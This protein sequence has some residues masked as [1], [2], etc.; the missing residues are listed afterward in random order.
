MTTA[1]ATISLVL[2]S[3]LML[4]SGCHKDGS[5]A[6]P[7]CLRAKLE[8]GGSDCVVKVEEYLFQGRK[9][10]RQVVDGCAD[11]PTTVVNAKCE[12]VCSCCGIT[13]IP[14]GPVEE[15]AQQATFVQVVWER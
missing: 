6:L 15:F 8:Q 2:V 5:E 14:E 10:Y 7:S 3:A 13:G 12:M 9:V 4:G 11:F 1:K